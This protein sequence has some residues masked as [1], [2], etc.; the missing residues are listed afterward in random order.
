MVTALFSIITLSQ[1][2]GAQ[3]ALNDYKAKLKAQGE[4]L[5]FGELGYPRVV[6]SN[7]CLARMVSGVGRLNSV[8]LTPGF[9]RLMDVSVPT[10]VQP[11][12]AGANLKLSDK[13]TTNFSWDVVGQRLA[14]AA[15]PLAE[16]R[17]A[18]R[19]PPTWLQTDPT[20]F[21]AHTSFQ[22]VAQRE[23]AQWLSA[24]IIFALHQRNL[25][26]AKENLQ[27]LLQL[28]HLHEDDPTLVS[29]MMRVAIAGLA[30]ATTWEALAAGG[31]TEADLVALQ[32]GW[33][34]FN[35]LRNLETGLLGERLF[36]AAIFDHFRNLSAGAQVKQ[37]NTTFAVFGHAS[38]KMLEYYWQLFVTTPIWRMNRERDELLVLRHQQSNIESVRRL[39][40]G[41]NW[42]VIKSELA[43]YK[44]EFDKTMD[45]PLASVRY[46][47]S[48]ILIANT[49]RAT[50]TAVHNETQRRLTV[51]AIALKRYE[52]RHQSTPATLA[53]LVPDFLSAVPVDPMSGKPLC[54][55]TN[56]TGYVL[57]SAG[58]DGVD[59]GGDPLPQAGSK[60]TDMWSGRDAV[61][62]SVT[63]V[64]P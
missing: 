62:P 51:T 16:I 9:I 10:N 46:S 11:V 35:L 38:H 57:Y 43:A 60:A 25:N 64:S 13:T 23:T 14:S 63:P 40:Q 28:V 19:H 17:A 31:W 47:L 29:Q 30:L 34:R 3:K 42:N 44:A 4:K 8:S 7:D 58:E 33:E 20:N 61:W 48:A 55:R 39:N 52:L 54:Y 6:E 49:E 50:Q 12:W 56:Q 2:S 21:S 53:T 26:P 15:E 32:T 5:S 41:T 45:E 36:S 59:D 1:K 24:E 27:A 22:V 37:M 18:L